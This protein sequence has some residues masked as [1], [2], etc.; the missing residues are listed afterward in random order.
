MSRR[1]LTSL[2]RT[3]AVSRPTVA[4]RF[5][6]GPSI[7]SFRAASTVTPPLI[8]PDLG[9]QRSDD[10]NPTARAEAQLR[11]FWKTVGIQPLPLNN[12]TSY[13][14]TLDGRP[15]KTPSGKKLEVPAERKVLALLIANEWENQKE[16][17]K[18][19]GLP[20]TSLASRA[21]DGMSDPAIKSGV[22][23]ELLRYLDTDTTCFPSD[24][25]S[26]IV[27][28]QK[29]HWEPLHAYFKQTHGV[30]IVSYETLVLGAGKRFEQKKETKEKLREVVLGWDEWQVSALE[31]ATYSTK[32]FLTAFALVDGHLTA[33]QAAQVA[34]V[35]VQSQIELWGEVEDSHDV[36]H[37]DIRRQ[38]GSVNCLLIK[39][40]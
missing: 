26:T 28:L 39:S 24:H 33:D 6:A 5:L 22:I 27:R 40:P 30:D 37:Q 2:L 31:R 13:L 29:T 36:D 4:S 17:M 14:I 25:P 21:L 15:L 35:E 3:A 9:K 12:P 20:M 1:S 8:T 38:L 34:L 23:D 32:S 16:I 7:A 19:S 11:R 10:P 18:V